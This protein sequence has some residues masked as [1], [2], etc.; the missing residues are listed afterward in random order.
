MN[1]W[2]ETISWPTRDPG[3][4]GK[5]VL[6][7]LI[8]LIPIIGQMCLFGWLMAALQNLRDGRQ[9]LPPAGFDFLGRGVNLFVVWLVYVLG[10]CV[11]LVV[12]FG[13]AIA[14]IAAGSNSSS[15]ATGA[16]GSLLFL[17]GYAVL[18]IGIL[19][20]YFLLPAVVLQTERG[21]IG[22]GLNVGQVIAIARSNGSVTLLAGLMTIL[23]YIIGGIGGVLCGIGAILTIAYGYAML[24]GIV[25]VYEQQIGY[26]AP[27]PPSYQPPYPPAAPV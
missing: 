7:G 10:L 14:I 12:L 20:L 16:L 18:L 5:V 15:G 26:G 19:A 9:E 6:M 2:G 1:D 21:G 22:A 17:L 24:A 3:W 27:A 23:A 8:S 13:L 11:V 25:R 4:M